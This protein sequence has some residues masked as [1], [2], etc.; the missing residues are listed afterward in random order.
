MK[1]TLV[2]LAT[3]A[4]AG[5]AFAQSGNARAITGSGVEI[6]GVADVAVNRITVDG[7][8]GTL[9]QL[10][11]GGRNES[12]RLGFR[13]MEDIGGGWGAGF[14]LEAGIAMDNGAGANTTT[15]NTVVGDKFTFTTASASQS[16][17]GSTATVAG[18]LNGRQGLTF[19]R[20]SVVSLLHRNIGEIR[21][22]RDYA[23]SFWNQT[24]FDPF[25][26]V[27]VGAFTNVSLGAASLNSQISSNP[28]PSV[29][30]SNS[31]GWLSND[32]GGI[33][34]QVQYAFSEMPTGC[35]TPLI[36]NTTNSG[37]GLNS[38]YCGGSNGDGRTIGYRLQ[39]MSGPLHLAA[40]YTQAQYG[41]VAAGTSV[42]GI[43]VAAA[44]QVAA[45]P[46]VPVANALLATNS[47]TRG[48]LA[49]TNFGGSYTVGAVKVM[50]QFGQ[51]VVDAVGPNTTA[52]P[53]KKFTY[54]LVG[55]TYTMGSTTLKA[56]VSGGNRS[57]GVIT[58]GTGTGT[59]EDGTKIAQTAIGFV[60]DLSKRTAVYGTYA[61]LK[62]TAGSASIGSGRV[63]MGLTGE[64][65]A[66]GS[67]ATTS[68]F[69]LGIRHRF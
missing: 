23:P 21:L 49:T 47:A 29:R 31:V 65:I 2:A 5:G 27:G 45:T 3:L 36:N 63:T 56:S 59:G 67:S 40:A 61:S 26:T 30:T 62:M 18:S 13:G 20:A 8:P 52:A 69:D 25:G 57:E 19:N 50:A 46:V 22:G 58:A 34:A 10:E 42:T 4:V 48:N 1:K 16:N 15:N 9:T 17:A 64:P 7:T 39:Y 11:G 12:T 38:N 53:S 68:G 33:R 32:M 44:P 51:Q 60:T 24:G 41:D 35:T 6:F 28:I 66:A 55:A 43:L 14:W 37:A 54:N